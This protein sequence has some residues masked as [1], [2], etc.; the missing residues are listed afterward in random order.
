MI[1]GLF[2]TTKTKGQA[3]AINLIELLNKYGLQKKIV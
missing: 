1:I 3:L 2:K